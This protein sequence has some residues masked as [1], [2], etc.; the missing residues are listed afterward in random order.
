MPAIT[1]NR[2]I[3]AVPAFLAFQAAFVFWAASR[4]RL[5]PK[6]DFSHFTVVV[7][8]WDKLRDDSIEPAIA[9]RLGADAWLDSIYVQRSTALAGDFFVA[10]FQSQRGGASQP[11]S[12][13]VCLPGAGWTFDNVGVTP[14]DTEDGTIPV[15]QGIIIRGQQRGALLYWYQT[16][17]HVI[18]SEWAAKFWVVADAAKYGRTDTSLVR[19][20]V[21]NGGKSDETTIAAAREFARKA[22]PALLEIF[23]R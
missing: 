17:R 5:P 12:P 23:P 9:A 22:Y 21:W 6:P 10:W 16:P 20:V 4:E 1:L 19:V 11:H 3:N 2:G 13:Q 15:N 14:L 18:A 7:G 8:D